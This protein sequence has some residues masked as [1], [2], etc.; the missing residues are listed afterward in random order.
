MKSLRNQELAEQNESKES[1]GISNLGKWR[2]MWWGSSPRTP[3]WS[4]R[5]GM[6]IFLQRRPKERPRKGSAA[7]VQ[8]G[9]N[10]QATI[11]AAWVKVAKAPGTKDVK[12]SMRQLNRINIGGAPY[13][14]A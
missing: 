11:W 5:R 1:S 7:R 12:A 10:A 6:K 2:K 3:R 4:P 14:A 8:G 13:F 9:R